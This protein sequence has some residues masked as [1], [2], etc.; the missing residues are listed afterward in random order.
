MLQS[1]EIHLTLGDS[2]QEQFSISDLSQEFEVTTRAIRF[3]EDEGLLEP[4]RKGRRRVYTVRDRVRLKLILRGKR[5]GF[6]LSEIG[7]I[8]TMYD[9]EPGEAGQ[10]HYFINKISAR[11]TVL[12]QQRDDIDVTLNELDAIEKQCRKTLARLP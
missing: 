1:T 4:R 2:G 3:Y 6:S 10:L 11:R 12:K 5:L 9:S 8:I 7:D